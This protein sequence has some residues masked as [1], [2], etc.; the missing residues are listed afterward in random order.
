MI[1]P[2]AR[3]VP[4]LRG[5]VLA[6]KAA[7]KTIKKQ[8]NDATR[9]EM[10]QPW[11]EAVA[12]HADG[13]RMDNTVF[14][15]GARV[16]AGNPARL[17][18]SSSRRPLRKGGNGFVPDQMGRALEFADPDRNR[19]SEYVRTYKGG[20]RHEVKRRTLTGYPAAKRGG[21]VV[22]PAVAE[23]MPRFVSLWVQIIVRNIHEALEGK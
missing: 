10:N 11:R 7:D 8:I 21:R 17:V 6:L 18:A 23:V 1:Q 2:S 14:G 13:S 15:K 20:K 4:V 19:K 3:T 9:S 16:A 22:Y 5:A 12:T